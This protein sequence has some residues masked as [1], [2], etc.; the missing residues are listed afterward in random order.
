MQLFPDN[1]VQVLLS[2]KTVGGGLCHKSYF[3][4]VW[5]FMT[6]KIQPG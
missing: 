2:A 4:R 5:I 1:Y 3:H 6:K